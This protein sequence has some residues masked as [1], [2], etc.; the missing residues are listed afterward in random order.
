M[1]IES[2]PEIAPHLIKNLVV[3]T[4]VPIHTSSTITHIAKDSSKILHA[5]PPSGIPVFNLDAIDITL[6]T[7]APCNFDS[8]FK[9]PKPIYNSTQGMNCIA[10]SHIG[11]AKSVRR[12]PTRRGDC[13]VRTCR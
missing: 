2:D 5:E 3:L 8:S 9:R 13:Y 1:T 6:R 10:L 11:I 12:P 4:L 7:S